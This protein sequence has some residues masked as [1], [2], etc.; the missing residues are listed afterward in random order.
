MGNIIDKIIMFINEQTAS[1]PQYKTI[2]IIPSK[3]IRIT[4]PATTSP[5]ITSPLVTSPVITSPVETSPPS[6]KTYSDFLITT[7]KVSQNE[8]N[9]I[10]NDAK[11]NNYFTSISYI[12]YLNN[13]YDNNQIFYKQVQNYPPI[14]NVGTVNSINED[15]EL[16]FSD[17]D[18]LG[19][20]YDIDG[21]KLNILNIRSNEGKITL[22]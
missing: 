13:N 3:T 1:T 4:S 21:D 19:S 8:W 18:L 10:V 22:R 6:I 9:D 20:T 15:S 14:L 7:R 2:I 11:K 12:D 5:I 16:L 17:A